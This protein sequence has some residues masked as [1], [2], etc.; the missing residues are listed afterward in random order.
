MCAEHC[1]IDKRRA[2]FTHLCVC[3][4]LFPGH[5]SQGSMLA[6]EDLREHVFE[7]CN[8]RQDTDTLSKT[9]P[10]VCM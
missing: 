8:L 4:Q 5:C 9:F 7:S 6:L 1:C 10:H 2:T 3:P